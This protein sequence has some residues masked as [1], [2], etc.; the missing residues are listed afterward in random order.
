MATILQD[1]R[2]VVHDLRLLADDATQ[3]CPSLDEP[4]GHGTARDLVDL[5]LLGSIGIALDEWKT[6]PDEEVNRPDF[7]GGSQC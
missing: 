3:H 6:V 2:D 1:L 7:P 4:K 5:V